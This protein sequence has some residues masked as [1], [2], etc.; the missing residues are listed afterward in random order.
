MGSDCVWLVGGLEDFLA[1][2]MTY[3]QSDFALA[4][5]LQKRSTYAKKT[6]VPEYATV[7]QVTSCWTSLAMTSTAS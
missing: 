4:V 6:C 5:A 2:S 3:H 1:G 7:A